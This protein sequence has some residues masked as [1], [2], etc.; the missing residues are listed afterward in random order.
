MQNKKGP[1]IALVLFVVVGAIAYPHVR[2]FQFEMEVR[3][4][5]GDKPGLG[6][7]PTREAIVA[8]KPKCIELAKAKGFDGL[9]VQLTLEAR[10]TGPKK[11][12]WPRAVVTAGDRT[13]VQERRA[14]TPF[15]EDQLEWFREQGVTVKDIKYATGEDDD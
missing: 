11:Y 3:G 4:V 2:W 6:R 1:L 13:F 12:W 14:E 15:P 8:V 5:F 10:M 7:F 9:K